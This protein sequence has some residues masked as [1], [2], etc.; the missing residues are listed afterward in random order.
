MTVRPALLVLLA[1]CSAPAL[2]PDLARAERLAHAGDDASA[3]AAYDAAVRGCGPE[4]RGADAQF[5]ASALRGRADALERLDRHE[6]AAAAYEAIPAQLPGDPATAAAAL[7]AAA[8]VRLALGQDARAYDLDWR[9]IVEYP[10]ES[11]ADDALRS[12]VADGRGRNPRELYGALRDLYARLAGTAV[13]DNLLWAMARIARDDLHDD[14]AALDALDRMVA[15]HPKSPFADDALW[16]GAALARA[17]HDPEGAL[18]RLRALL[19]TRETSWIVGSYLS[20]HLPPAALEVGRILR[21]DL[22]QPREALAAFAR[23]GADYPTSTLVDDALYETAVTHAAL[24]DAAAACRDLAELARRFPESRYEIEDA[25]RLAA[26][27][28]CR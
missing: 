3:L 4:V 13:G 16:E 28:G 21:D 5:C 11:A 17:R 20:P 23:V 24:G 25:P 7:A 2:P 9:V 15:A 14:A 19:A 26:R 10:D 8:R 6:D 12:V 22:G 1:A 18:R 27:T